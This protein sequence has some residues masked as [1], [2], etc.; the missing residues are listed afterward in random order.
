M[1]EKMISFHSELLNNSYCQLPLGRRLR[2]LTWILG[3][4]KELDT[5]ILLY[6]GLLIIWNS[7]KWSNKTKIAGVFI[8]FEKSVGYVLFTFLTWASDK[9]YFRRF[10]FSECSRNLIMIYALYILKRVYLNNLFVKDS[11]DF[12]NKDIIKKWNSRGVFVC[13]VIL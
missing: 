7:G 9:F 8:R 13:S 10:E 12:T 6:Q 3:H 5:E 1:G 2:F 11:E 4:L